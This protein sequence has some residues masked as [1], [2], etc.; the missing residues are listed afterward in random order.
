MCFVFIYSVGPG[1][2]TKEPDFMYL[3]QVMG[4]GFHIIWEK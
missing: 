4:T 1:D 2:V 3:V